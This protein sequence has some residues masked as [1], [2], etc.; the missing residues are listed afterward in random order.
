MQ[1]KDQPWFGNQDQMA[2]EDQN[3]ANVLRKLTKNKRKEMKYKT[4]QVIDFWKYSIQIQVLDDACLIVF[5]YI[6]PAKYVP[7]E[8]MS[9]L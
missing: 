5:T 3:G 8:D 9:L 6:L 1:V 4:C 2:A 7:T